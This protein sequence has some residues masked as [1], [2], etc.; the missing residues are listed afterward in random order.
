MKG[1][2]VRSVVSGDE[3]DVAS[4]HNVAFGEWVETLGDEYDYQYISP[5]DVAAW[6]KERRD[7]Q[8]C[9]WIAETNDTAVGYVHCSLNDIHSKKNLKELVLV[10]TSWDMGQ[11]KIAVIPRYRR[12][13]IASAL[14]WKCVKHFKRAGANLALAVAYNDNKAASKLLQGLGFVHHERFYHRPYS[15]KRPWRHDTVYAELNLSQPV[16]SPQRLNL[17]VT[18]RCAREEDAKRVAEI[19]RK[20]APW[21]PF[22]PNVSTDQILQHY[23]KGKSHET[24]L[25]AEYKGEIAGVMDFNS[26]NSRLGILGV[27]PEYRKKGIG[28]TLFYHLLEHMR[29][30][31][32]PKA[33]A[34]TGIVL[35]DAIR[36]YKRFNLKIVRRQYSWIKILNNDS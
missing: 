26:K 17:H 19:F 30:K 2:I 23:L 34:D 28:Y 8:E 13:A 12:Q 27:A 18:V 4:I 5:R 9:L 21:T 24:I 16:T 11:S 20:S 29:R 10:P 33:I 7:R 36:M 1:V 31:G 32:L 35:S 3:D 6:I 25:V 15:D 22:G 14:V